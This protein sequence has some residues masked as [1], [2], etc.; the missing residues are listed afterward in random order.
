MPPSQ[1]YQAVARNLSSLPPEVLHNVLDDIPFL[2]IL[3]I[4]TLYDLPYIE[5]CVLSHVRYGQ[6]FRTSESLSTLKQY[7]SLYVYIS[8]RLRCT[9][10][11]ILLPGKGPDLFDK[12]LA[13][14]QAAIFQF[15]KPFDLYTQ[16]LSQY[17]PSIAAGMPDISDHAALHEYWKSL[18]V[19]EDCLNQIKASQLERLAQLYIQYPGMLKRRLDTSQESRRM[20]EQHQIE[21]LRLHAA[22][23]LKAQILGNKFIAKTIFAEL[24]FPVIPY[25]RHLKMF[26]RILHKFPLPD[27]LPS[28]E[29][30]HPVKYYTWPENVISDITT[31]T[32]GLAYVYPKASAK[33]N[34]GPILRTMYTC[35]SDKDFAKASGKN[36][37]Q[38]VGGIHITAKKKEHLHYFDP[39]DNILPLEEREFEWIE[40]FLRTCAYMR[41]M[42][43]VEWTDGITIKQFW[44]NH[45]GDNLPSTSKSLAQCTRPELVIT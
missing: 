42:D 8:Q 25:D 45:T 4:I 30:P 32:E 16:A 34:Y 44:V 35:Y 27:A 10:K 21:A 17:C 14:V 11:P 2:R 19:A 7:L 37:P 24:R 15:L 33:G 5:Q 13:T 31:V 29:E 6:L 20:T 12:I 38:F 9:R 40:A 3:E 18:N 43:D 26:L 23:M 36:Q 22:K 41:Q 1:R 39:N 28:A